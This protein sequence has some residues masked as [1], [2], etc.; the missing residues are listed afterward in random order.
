[1][2]KSEVKKELIDLIIEVFKNQEFDANTIEYTDLLEDFGMDSLSFISL[3]IEIES[4]F[5]ITIPDE[6]LLLDNFKFVDDIVVIVNQEIVKKCKRRRKNNIIMSKLE[7]L[8]KYVS[9][10]N[11]FYKKLIKE[12]CIS[13]PLDITQYPIL[14]R[15]LLQ[16]NRYGMFSDGYKSK[17]FSQQLR[18]RSSSGSS[19]IPVNVY[20]D[21]RDWY[22]A[23]MSVWRKRIQWYGIHPKHTLSYSVPLVFQVH[24]LSIKAKKPWICFL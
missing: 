11:E 22:A 2:E 14:T 6:T 21:N 19:G 9:E 23:N 1:M 17:Y 15:Q 13:N 20:W 3:V 8:L 24:F 7:K 4:H 18:R 12:D 5:K 16:E 10:H